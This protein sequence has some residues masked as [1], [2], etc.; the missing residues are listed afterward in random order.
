MSI[1]VSWLQKSED[2]TE[3][4]TTTLLDFIELPCS[5]SGENMAEALA[6][7]LREYGIDGKVSKNLLILITS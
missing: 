1:V 6:K 2:G 4:L 7:T 5:H 3:E